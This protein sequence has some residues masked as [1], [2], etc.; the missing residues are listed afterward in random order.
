VKAAHEQ[1]GIVKRRSGLLTAAVYPYPLRH[2][3]ADF[4]P[5]EVES[6]LLDR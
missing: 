4:G 1:H 6:A 2:I 3:I 5:G